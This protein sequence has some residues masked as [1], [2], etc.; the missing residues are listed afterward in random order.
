MPGQRT[1]SPQPRPGAS[2]QPVRGADHSA[3]T[4]LIPLNRDR[5]A[6]LRERATSALGQ[7]AKVDGPRVDTGSRI[8]DSATRTDHRAPYPATIPPRADITPLWALGRF[9]CQALRFPS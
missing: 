5:E 2:P 6:Y 8:S 3:L 4:P 7:L 1:S 9:D